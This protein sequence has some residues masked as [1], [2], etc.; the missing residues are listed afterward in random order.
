LFTEKIA[1]SINVT[2]FVGIGKT[3]LV[4]SELLSTMMR[5]FGVFRVKNNDF[6]PKNLIFSNFRGAPPLPPPGAA[7]EFRVADRKYKNKLYKKI[8]LSTM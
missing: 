5:M 3:G 4:S 7:P 1:K 6:T 2:V 8:Y